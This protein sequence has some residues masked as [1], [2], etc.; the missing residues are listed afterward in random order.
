MGQSQSEAVRSSPP[1]STRRNDL[2][3]R[4]VVVD[5]H[6][7]YYVPRNGMEPDELQLKRTPITFLVPRRLRPPA[8]TKLTA[9]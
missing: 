5:D 4:E 6:V 9:R 8:S 7:K 3:G 1:S 2:I